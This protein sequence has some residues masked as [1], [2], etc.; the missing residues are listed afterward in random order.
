MDDDNAH[1]DTLAFIL[2]DDLGAP[3]RDPFKSASEDGRG[4]AERAAVRRLRRVMRD[5]D[6]GEDEMVSALRDAMSILKE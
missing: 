3:T 1:R 4:E 2:G 6:G 5:D